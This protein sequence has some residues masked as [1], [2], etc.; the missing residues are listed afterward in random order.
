VTLAL[1]FVVYT[2]AG[3]RITRLVAADKITE[4]PRNAIL[5][6]LP[7]GS[8]AAY[9]LACRWCAGFWISLP[10]AAV[11]WWWPWHWWSIVPALALAISYVTG[12]LGSIEGD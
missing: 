5:R 3:A 12:L 8:L 6:R 1:A 11:A 2:L 10:V 9:L 7:D 4:R